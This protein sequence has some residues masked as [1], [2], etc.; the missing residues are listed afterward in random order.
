MD[1]LKEISGNEIFKE[2]FTHSVVGMSIT[3]IEGRLNANAS[4][5]EMIGYSKEELM[6]QK[7]ED[8]THPDDIEPN[9][10]IIENILS[11]RNK[12][13]RWEKRYL[14]KNSSI[15]WVD[16]HTVLLRDENGNPLHFVT[17]VYDISARK[18]AEAGRGKEITAHG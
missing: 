17:T 8:Y 7:W 18:H 6:N 14:H 4:F 11:G 1:L 5:C 16:I 9:W 15:I 10:I 2:L 3:S 13:V 12:S